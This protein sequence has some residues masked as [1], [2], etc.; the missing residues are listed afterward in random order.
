MDIF[1][2]L[3]VGFGAVLEPSNL[4]FCFIGCLLGTAVGVLP[5]IG[6][7]GTIAILLPVTFGFPPEA[8]MIMLAGIYYGAQYGGSTTAI[9]IN[10]PGEATSAVT[11]IDGYQMAR[12]GRAGVALAIAAL[13]SFFAGCFATLVIALFAVPLT[14]LA[15]QFGPSDYFAL[16]VLGVVASIALAHGSVLKGLVMIVLGLLLGCVGTDVYT[17][18]MRLT[19]GTLDLAD[20]IPIIAFGSG[21]YAIAE[22][23]RGLEDER[24]QERD[25]L[26][27]RVTGLMPSWADIR[28]SAGP[29]LRGTGLG[30]ILGILPGGGAMLSSFTSYALEKKLSRHP[31]RFGHGAL[32]GVAGPESANNAGAQSS[33]IPMLTLG[34]PSNP[35]MALMI[36]ALMLQGVAPGPNLVNE[37]PVLFWGVIVSMWIGN[38]MLVVLNLPLV[39]L[40]VKLLS[41][42]NHFLFPAIIGFSAIGVYSVGNNPFDLVV[43]AVFGVVGYGLTKLDCEPAPLLLGFVLG[44]MLEEYLRR[45][46]LL[47]NGNP[48]TFFQ[49]PITAGLLIVAAV[50]LFAV[51]FPA[52]RNSRRVVFAEED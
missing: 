13:G 36:G 9:L 15:L 37:R 52:I 38:L 6:P 18:S 2:N 7:L 50:T 32:A 20:G 17:G 10:L 34:I 43:M 8:S 30:S 44:P 41:V 39:G 24:E 14:T 28:E 1:A 16:M 40:W 21:V 3:A 4:L 25:V 23:L 33:F 22:I 29:I 19:L 42:R 12:Q 27:T 48:L 35:I 49:R 51:L 5:G 47:A 26:T 31:E 45:A 46:M 11:A